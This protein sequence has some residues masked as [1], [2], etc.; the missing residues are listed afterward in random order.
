MQLLDFVDACDMRSKNEMEIFELLCYYKMKEDGTI[1]F[2][3]KKI[4][5]VYE[6]A[7]LPVPERRAMEKQT[8]KN[9]HF[10]PYGIEGTLKFAS[11]VVGS[12]DKMYGHLWSAAAAQGP[13]STVKASS[14]PPV[15]VQLA[16][17]AEVS[18]ISSKT[19]IERFELLCYYLT[20]EEGT[21]KFAVGDMTDTYTGAGLDR[22]DRSAL[23]KQIK[24][25]SSFVSRGIDGKVEFAP[26]AL[27]ALDRVYGYL[28]DDTS[29]ASEPK[30]GAKAA[31]AGFEVISEERFC[32]KRDG[33][34]RLIVQIN[35]TY[36]DGS[37]DACAS[38]MRRLME[39]VLILSFQANNIENEIRKGGG[40]YLG[41][42][43]IVKK[44]AASDVLRLSEKG[45]DI[46]MISKIG[47]YGG[48]GPMYTFGANDINAV[49]TGYRNVLET[50]CELAK[51][52]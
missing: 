28:W 25:H 12:F 6:E 44:A 50:L 40:D 3:V 46:S 2:S 18:K 4:L 10:R 19:D 36:R 52:L 35:A 1:S 38:V 30:F 15:C 27:G 23:A 9:P 13:L 29:P 7:G 33:L 11:G 39:S 49:R 37:F 14:A 45:I 51:L 41:Y 26:G 42:E 32:G 17:F 16:D 48:K 20:K 24:K 8:K 43:D 21:K 31:S 47:D 34:D 5:A 22:P